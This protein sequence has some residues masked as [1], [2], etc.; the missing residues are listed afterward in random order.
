M[1]K[2]QATIEFLTSAMLFILILVGTLHVLSGD[3]PEFES[4]VDQSSKN[5]EMYTLTDR[6]LS[7]PGLTT[8]GVTNWED[9]TQNTTEFGLAS[10]HLILQKDKID[11]LETVSGDKLNYSQFRSLTNVNHQ[12]NFKFVWLPVVETS[13]N[14]I[15]GNPPT[16]PNIIEPEDQEYAQ[17]QNRVHYG[18]FKVRNIEYKFLVTAHDG[19]YDTARI[20][21]DWNFTREETKNRGK[22]I[23]LNGLKFTLKTFQN[24]EKR[25]GAAIILNRTIKTFG[26]NPDNSENQ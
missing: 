7:E 16:K 9:N 6:I 10:D 21:T 26:S 23:T 15:K 8:T 13:K 1:Q 5:M 2:G 18:T 25:P 12:Y 24:R 4:S 20:S 17:A 22:I 19:I 3:I 11:S 14:F